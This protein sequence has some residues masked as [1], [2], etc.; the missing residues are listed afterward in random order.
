M[1]AVDGK[2]TRLHQ[3]TGSHQTTPSVTQNNHGA[4][5]S[6]AVT[7]GSAHRVRMVRLHIGDYYV[8]AL[9]NFN[10]NKFGSKILSPR[11]TQKPIALRMQGIALDL[12]PPSLQGGYRIKNNLTHHG[13]ADSQNPMFRVLWERCRATLGYPTV[14]ANASPGPEPSELTSCSESNL[15]TATHKQS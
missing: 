4:A 6:D 5:V 15:F 14:L 8:S 1:V 7:A 9:H 12:Y 2:D 3:H 11:Q 13:A 10:N